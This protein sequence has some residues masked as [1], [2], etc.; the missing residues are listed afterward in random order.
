MLARED[1]L[2]EFE[3]AITKLG[4]SG[5][6]STHKHRWKTPWLSRIL[7]LLWASRELWCTHSYSSYPSSKKTAKEAMNQIMSFQ[8]ILRL[9]FRDFPCRGTSRLQWLAWKASKYQVITHH[10][11]ANGFVLW[12]GNNRCHRTKKSSASIEKGT[13]RRTTWN[14]FKIFFMTPHIMEVSPTGICVLRLRAWQNSLRH[15]LSLGPEA[16]RMG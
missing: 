6:S 16:V 14:I 1:A 9:A 15:W 10:L 11:G 7:P 13:I 12:S 5:N 4:L 2:E 8:T 3:R